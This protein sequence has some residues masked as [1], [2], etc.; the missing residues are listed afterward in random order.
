M[1]APSSGWRWI[2]DPVVLGQ[3]P[4][5]LGDPVGQREV[6]DVV[7]QPGGVGEL[8]FLRRSSRPTGPCR[9]RT[10]RPPRRGARRAGRGYRASASARRAPPTTARHIAGHGCGPGR[11]DGPCRRTRTP[12][13]ARRRCRRKPT[14]GRCRRPPPPART[15]SAMAGQDRVTPEIPRSSAAEQPAERREDQKADRDV[16]DAP[17]ARPAIDA[18]LSA[19]RGRR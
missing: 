5:A 9:A 4:S 13:R 3:R 11:A 7:Q 15:F 10:A 12:R 18:G 8:A 16:D 17:R 19:G 1:S 14:S 6:A 2:A